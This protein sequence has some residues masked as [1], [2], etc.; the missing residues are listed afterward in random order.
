LTK[1]IF[2]V[3]YTHKGKDMNIT[4][5]KANAIQ[6]AIN[7]TVKSIDLTT[8]IRINEFQEPET[9]IQQ[10]SA[11]FFANANRKEQLLNSLYEIR[12]AVSAAN[13]SVG[14]DSKLA[15]VAHLDKSIQFYNTFVGQSV[16]ESAQ[17][18]SGK[19]EKIRQRK[20]DSRSIY[21][22]EDEVTTSIF[23]REDVD[24]FRRVV[25]KAKKTKQKLQDEILELNVRTEIALSPETEAI[26]QTEG[27]V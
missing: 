23:T 25:A 24:G 11:K 21:G 18:V 19:L 22:R 27:L 9:E 26:L 2:T 3:Q 17:V 12:K 4:L 8:T 6:N 5:R 7:D 1:D 13:S 14:I 15:D 16:R 10:A 20:E